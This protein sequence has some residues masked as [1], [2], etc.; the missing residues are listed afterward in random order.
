MNKKQTVKFKDLSGPCKFAIVGGFIYLV[1]FII[2]FIYG[3]VVGFTGG[4]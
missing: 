3:F 4:I 1:A 2:M